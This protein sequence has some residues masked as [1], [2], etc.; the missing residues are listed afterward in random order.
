MYSV[1]DRKVQ[2]CQGQCLQHGSQAAC[3]DHKGDWWRLVGR[4]V[5]QDAA[6]VREQEVRAC[7]FFRHHSHESIR[8][9]SIE[10]QESLVVC[11]HGDQVQVAE[12]L[13]TCEKLSMLSISSS[14]PTMNLHLLAAVP[15]APGSLCEPRVGA[16]HGLVEFRP[17]QLT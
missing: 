3:R 2:F 15:S 11:V 7:V 13:Q 17:L 14:P 8:S 12:A 5:G 16:S 10:A 6:G 9:E 1:S 4:P